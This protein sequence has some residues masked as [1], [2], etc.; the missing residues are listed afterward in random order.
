MINY[1][2]PQVTASQNILITDLTISSIKV[3]MSTLLLAI[4]CS[5]LASETLGSKNT[6]C[7]SECNSEIVVLTLIYDLQKG[8]S[9][10][11]TCIAN[12]I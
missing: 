4:K 8:V 6:Q 7:I 9:N 10:K 11:E 1:P 2:T 12:I 3:T 5:H